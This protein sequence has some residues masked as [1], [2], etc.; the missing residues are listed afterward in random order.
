VVREAGDGGGLAD[1]ARGETEV[2]PAQILTLVAW[3]VAVAVI[4]V[5]LTEDA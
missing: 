3:A 1:T 4:F 2:T 5:V